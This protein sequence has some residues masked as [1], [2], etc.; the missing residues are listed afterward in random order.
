M[1]VSDRDL[2]WSNSCDLL[3][4]RRACFVSDGAC[5]GVCYG[6]CDGVCDGVSGGVVVCDACGGAGV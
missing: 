5:Y 3:Y 1:L 4:P 6:V 2:A